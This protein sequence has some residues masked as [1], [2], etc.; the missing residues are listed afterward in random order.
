MD[1]IISKLSAIE[2]MSQ[3]YI[4]DAILKKKDIAAEMEAKKKLWKDDLDIKTK[5]RIAA[6]QE[7][8]NAVKEKKMSELKQQSEK[9]SKDMQSIYDHYHDKYVDNLFSEMIKE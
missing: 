5:S 2:D 1:D 4:D 7:E 3:S 6:L 8:K 9:S